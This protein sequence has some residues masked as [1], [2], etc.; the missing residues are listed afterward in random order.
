MHCNGCTMQANGFPA[1]VQGGMHINTLFHTENGM[2][3]SGYAKEAD[4]MRR[5]Q[6]GE[7]VKE[8]AHSGKSKD[9]QPV[10]AIR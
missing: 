8:S 2:Y 9:K 3:T 1:I 10:P 7:R 6:D 5:Q 4:S